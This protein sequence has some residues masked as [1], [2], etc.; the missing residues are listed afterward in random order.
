MR[1]RKWSMQN[2]SRQQKGT[3]MN[4]DSTYLATGP[5]AA[6]GSVT[7]DIVDEIIKTK[8]GKEATIIEQLEVVFHLFQLFQLP[9][10]PHPVTTS[11]VSSIAMVKTEAGKYRSFGCCE[12]GGCPH[13]PVDGIPRK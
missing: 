6:T 12:L 4:T 13:V 7:V 8:E 3:A 2:M 5:T 10:S 11:S 9:C 1:H